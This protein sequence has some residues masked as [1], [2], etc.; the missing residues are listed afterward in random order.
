[1]TAPLLSVRGLRTTFPTRRGTLVAA[2]DVDL[3]I[4]AGEALGVDPFDEAG[5][6]A[7]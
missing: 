3:E 5:F 4:G 1:M 7:E 6:A 2:D